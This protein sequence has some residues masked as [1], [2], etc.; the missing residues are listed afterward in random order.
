[1]ACPTHVIQ[2]WNG[3]Y[4]DKVPLRKLGMRYQVGHLAGEV[5]L[6]LQLAFHN[7]FTII[8]TN[9][10]H[11]IALDFCSCMQKH[12]FAMQL[13]GAW[14]FPATD[15]Q[16][17]TTVMTT[18][19][20]QFQM[21]TFMGKISAYEYYHS[22]VCL[23]DNTGIT[24]PSDN[25]DTFI[26]VVCEWSFICL[27]KRAGIGNNCGR[28]K[29]AKPGSCAMECLTFPHPGINILESVD[30]DS[31]NAWE[32]TLY[33]GMDANFC[34]KRFNVLSEEKDPGLSKGLTYFV[35]TKTFHKHLADFDKQII[36]PPSL[37]SNHEAVKGDKRG[38]IRTRD[39]AASGLKIPKKVYLIPKFHLPGHIKDCQEKYCMSFH[40]HIGEND[41]E[42]PECSWAISND[43]HFGDFNWHKNVLQGDTLLCKIKDAM[44]KASDHEDRFKHFSALLPQSDVVKWTKMVEDWEVDRSKPNPFS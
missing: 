42:A 32:D 1:M 11:D 35:D 26:C 3:N 9:G 27:L 30:L 7:H 38:F 18:A 4:F 43:Q 41:G 6:H 39:L 15:I 22:L 13:Q 16:P 21:L 29:V 44:P 14:L 5:C 10:I 19:L 37:C 25:F 17:C 31:P 23:T 36:Q 40:I 24:A 12:L 2:S 34:L 28:W 8:D 33:I 20:E